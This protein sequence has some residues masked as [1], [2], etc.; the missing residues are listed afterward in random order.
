MIRSVPVVAVTLLVILAGCGGQPSYALRPIVDIS[1]ESNS[2]HVDGAV[3]LEGKYGDELQVKGVIVAY[4]LNGT[5]V[6]R[7]DLGT[8][9]QDRPRANFS[10]TAPTHP[11]E[12]R[13]YYR[14]VTP[15]DYSGTTYYLEW[16]SERTIYSEEVARDPALNGTSTQ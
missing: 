6:D 9:D 10:F 11:D 14:E 15:R 4:K 1:E 16:N 13:V 2:I 12:I 8:L 7:F 3:S 5:T